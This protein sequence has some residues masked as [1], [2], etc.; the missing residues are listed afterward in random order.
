MLMD[1]RQ[2]VLMKPWKVEG[3]LETASNRPGPNGPSP[4]PATKEGVVTKMAEN[5]R[6]ATS[7]GINA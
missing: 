5:W 7:I 3:W 4:F 6:V 2:L 1:I